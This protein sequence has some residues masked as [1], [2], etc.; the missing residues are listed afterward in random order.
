MTGFSSYAVGVKSMQMCSDT[1]RR[2]MRDY[3]LQAVRLRTEGD[4]M[5]FHLALAV[6]IDFRDRAKSYDRRRAELQEF[7]F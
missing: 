3:A 5:S 7:G 6:A 1:A 4:R 2:L